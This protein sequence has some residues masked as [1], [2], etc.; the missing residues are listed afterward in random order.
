MSYHVGLDCA[1]E[2]QRV[3]EDVTVAEQKKIKT[4]ALYAERKAVKER[5][6]D[7]NRGVI[8]QAKMQEL[9]IQEKVAGEMVAT[10]KQK[11]TEKKLNLLAQFKDLM[12]PGEYK[13]KV[14]KQLA[15]LDSS[16][17]EE[18]ASVEDADKDS[19]DHSDDSD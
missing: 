19:S 17:S 11:R 15:K 7:M 5:A 9:K 13:R 16:S 10:S 8:N 4:S 2:E 6:Q 12:S 3:H 18:E 14:R 1:P